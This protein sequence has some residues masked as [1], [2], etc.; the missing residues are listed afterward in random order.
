[1]R[2]RDSGVHGGSPRGRIGRRRDPMMPTTGPL[3]RSSSMAKS[4][5]SS[6]LEL[7]LAA[8][9]H[10]DG[11]A[12]P[13]ARARAPRG[14]PRRPP[15]PARPCP[16]RARSPASW[17]VAG[18]RR[19]GVR[20]AGRR[21]LSRRPA[22]RRDPGRPGR[23]VAAPP[24][25][26]PRS[27]RALG[28]TSDPGRPDVTEFPRAAWLRSLRRV[29]AAAPGRPPRPTSAGRGVPGAPDR[30][31]RVPQ[32]RPRHRRRPGGRRHQLRLR[33]GARARRRRSLAARGGS[34]GSPSRTRPTPT[35]ARSFAAG[36][37][38]PVA[39]PVDERRP[40]VDD[41]SGW[42]DGRRAVLV[43]A[44]HQY[45][46]GGVL[47]PD[48]RAALLDWA[49][50]TRRASSSRTTTTRSS[51]TTASRSARSRDSAPTTSSTPARRARP[52]RPGSGSAGSRR[53]PSLVEP[54]TAAKQAADRVA[55]PRPAR[56]R[57][58]PRARR[59]RPLTCAGCGRSTGAGATPCSR[60][61]P[62]TCPAVRAGRRLGRPPRARLAPG[63]PGRGRRSVAAAADAGIA[64]Y[65]LTPRRI[66]P[67]RAGL[68]FGYGAGPGGRDRGQDRAAGG[69]PGREDRVRTRTGEGSAASTRGA[70]TRDA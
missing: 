2:T 30:A 10:H 5:T 54:I 40:R 45:P 51:A 26:G 37:L 8:R 4:R 62:A 1:M 55:G 67:G 7:L 6:A 32:P 38:E 47:P 68:V 33:A 29:L 41:S 36:G 18:H 60:P 58:P 16:R 17:G 64:V 27:T 19:G 56:L 70:G 53:P 24:P 69:R 42:T 39:I 9:P 21:G 34:H 59:A 14:G 44:A 11:A 48:R 43:T 65:G 31:R 20:A 13:P 15:R 66:A 61:S 52:S 50:R 35:T 12:P 25:A 23:R 57:G 46:T 28:S 49:G 3:I 22:R 63:R